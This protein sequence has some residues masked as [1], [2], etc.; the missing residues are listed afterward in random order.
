[1]L[2]YIFLI[3]SML[4]WLFEISGLLR[5][6]LTGV[7]F[8]RSIGLLADIL[9]YPIAAEAFAMRCLPC[10]GPPCSNPR[11]LSSKQS[12]ELS[13]LIWPIC[14][15]YGWTLRKRVRTLWP[16]FTE[17]NKLTVVPMDNYSVTHSVD[18]GPKE[19]YI[20]NERSKR[21]AA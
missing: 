17:E 19:V 11:L 18:S 9:T 20:T 10:P 2:V 1:M 5:C 7:Y 13:V 3:N 16:S 12:H 8:V 6:G 21:T 4:K 15:L 14:L